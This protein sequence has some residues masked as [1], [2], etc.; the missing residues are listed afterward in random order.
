MNPKHIK[1]KHGVTIIAH[2]GVQFPS[3]LNIIFN[4]VHSRIF[5]FIY[6]TSLFLG[7][8]PENVTELDRGW[9]LLRNMTFRFTEKKVN[10]TSE[11]F[12]K[13][14]SS[15]KKGDQSPMF[16]LLCKFVRKLLALPHSSTNVEIVFY[17]Y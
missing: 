17:N 13:N 14:V 6:I 8:C 10:P 11:K 15:V 2:L 9:R 7:L 4:V 16:P 1:K 3:K 12:W 5:F